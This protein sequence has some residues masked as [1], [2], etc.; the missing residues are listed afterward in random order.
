MFFGRNTA[1]IK[2]SERKSHSISTY[3][4]NEYSRPQRESAGK[5]I[6]S[7]CEKNDIDRGMGGLLHRIA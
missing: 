5:T 6:E 1:D 7:T 4:R 3:R 2:N